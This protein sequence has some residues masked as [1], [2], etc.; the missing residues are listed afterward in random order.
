MSAYDQGGLIRRKQVEFLREIFEKEN[1][2]Q[3]YVIVGGDFNQVLI[4]EG[5][6]YFIK[7]PNGEITPSWVATWEGSFPGYKIVATKEGDTNK[8]TG[9]ARNN[10]KAYDPDWTYTC[11]IDGFITSDNITVSEIV[12]ITSAEFKY[13][14]HIPVKM[15]FTLN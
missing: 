13:S 14:D 3:N 4:P 10:T 11:V 5:P 9:T 7:K 2:A 12:N 15:Q 8:P 6:E 1:A